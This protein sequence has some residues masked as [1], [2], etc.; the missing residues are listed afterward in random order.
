MSL[1][2]IIRKIHLFIGLQASI[3][4]MMFSITVFSL[5]TENHEEPIIS[6][7]KF[8]GSTDTESLELAIVLYDQVGKRFEAVPKRWMVSDKEPDILFVK[9][10][11]PKG[12]REIRLN[13]TNGDM[14]IRAWHSNF[15][16]FINYMHQEGFGRRQLSDSLWL[17][18][19]SF[20][21]ELSVLAL[22][23]LPVTGLYIWVVG[24][25][26]KK[27]WAK[28]SLVSPIMIVV[29]LWNLIR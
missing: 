8:A 10:K 15:P 9:F 7:Q 16:E 28:L 4:L 11:S 1:D 17:W 18:A 3:S 24:R 6:H 25:S 29:M 27:Y 12:K 5:S 20:Y 21:L 2:D 13:K 14:E 22:F 26:V 23:I 19:W